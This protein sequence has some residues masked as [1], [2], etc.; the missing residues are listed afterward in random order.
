MGEQVILATIATAVTNTNLYSWTVPDII[1][2]L[3]RV[4][5][6]NFDD[7]LVLDAS[8]AN[9]TVKGSSGCDRA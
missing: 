3:V 8:N 9:F 2:T 6:A 1:G 7:A 5:V 4:Q